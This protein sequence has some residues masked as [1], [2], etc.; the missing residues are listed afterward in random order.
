MKIKEL[1]EW[2]ART[3]SAHDQ[4]DVEV[5]L[6]GSRITLTA[7]PGHT[8]RMGNTILIEGN[9]KPGRKVMIVT[10]AEHTLKL[11]SDFPYDAPDSWWDSSAT[12]V[13]PV[14]P[15]PTDWAHRAARGVIA[16]LQDRRG[17]KQ[18]FNDIDEETRK[19]IVESLAAIIRSAG[20]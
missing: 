16:D 14:P 13:T 4:C 19:E 20:P 7:K 8:M 17:I 1:R 5:W 15:P 10:D 3:N 18:E 9:V 2:I 12:S 6:P 11:G